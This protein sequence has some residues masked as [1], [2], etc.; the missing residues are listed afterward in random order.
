MYASEAAPSTPSMTV[1]QQPISDQP[2]FASTDALNDDR[3]NRLVEAIFDSV[4]AET[5]AENL[6]EKAR[7]L[8][9]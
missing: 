8:R 9:F 6:L 5:L 3:P 2:Q 4:P 7:S 1:L